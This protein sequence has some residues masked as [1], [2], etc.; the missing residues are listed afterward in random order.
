VLLGAAGGLPNS[1][2]QPHS[3]P[4]HT[5]GAPHRGNGHWPAWPFLGALRTKALTLTETM[6]VRVAKPPPGEAKPSKND[7]G[8]VAR[9]F[10]EHRPR[11][12]ALQTKALTLTEP[13]GV[14]VAKPPPREAKP[15]KN[16]EGDVARAFRE[17]TS[18]STSWTILGLNQ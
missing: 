11:S 12:T 13:M 8:D 4:F 9:A 6:G 5:P 15:S 3:W 14:R 10:R 16:D 17:H 7:E 2:P 1:R 18:P